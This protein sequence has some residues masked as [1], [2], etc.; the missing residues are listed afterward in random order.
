MRCWHLWQL[1]HNRKYSKISHF[2]FT[3]NI[4]TITGECV[5]LSN[6]RALCTMRT[7]E[8][9]QLHQFS[10]SEL[11]WHKERKSSCPVA[12]SGEDLADAISN[13]HWGRLLLTALPFLGKDDEA[14]L[15]YL[16]TTCTASARDASNASTN[17]RGGQGGPWY[18]HQP[19][20]LEHISG[21]V[22]G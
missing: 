7:T 16:P 4:F 15:M 8:R 22:K 5:R 21:C 10:T 11:W 3:L 13:D 9:N 17:T 6:Q 1:W 2:V 12:A 14:N 18:M 20:T 19:P